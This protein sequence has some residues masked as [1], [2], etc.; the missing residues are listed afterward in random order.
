MLFIACSCFSLLRERSSR[1]SSPYLK[2]RRSDRKI[3]IIEK[4]NRIGREQDR[5]EE[6]FLSN[7]RSHEHIRTSELSGK[8]SL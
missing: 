3:K 7:P 5:K 6:R 8:Y 4:S 1:S 2:K